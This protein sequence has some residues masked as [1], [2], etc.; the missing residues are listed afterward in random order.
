MRKI[1]IDTDCGV[2]DAVAIMM[3]LSDKRVKVE[4][5]TTVSGNVALEN[6]VDNV[7]RILS[8]FDRKEIPVFRGA[9]RP[10]V[11]KVRRAEGVHGEN[12]LGDVILPAPSIEE[13][14]LIAPEGLY[15]IAC[16]NP[17]I[18]LVTLG[19]LTNIAIAF[20]LFPELASLIGDI[21]IM[22]GA[23]ERGNITRFAEFN[24]FADPESAQFVF[25]TSVPITVIPW[26]PCFAVM[27]TE[28][29]L[30]N[31]GMEGGKAGEFFLKLQRKPIDYIEK[32]YG[33]RAVALPDPAA[34]ACVLD[35]RTALRRVCGNM[36]LELNYTTMRGA[37]VLSEGHRMDI[38]LEIDKN[39]FTELLR[40]IKALD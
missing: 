15:R 35:S 19:P 12:G 30:I 25:N 8:Y 32:Y 38:I 28:E 23:V 36:T 31:L 17:G 2:D 6:V 9:S 39:R 20:N 33:V 16:E 27:Y 13:R 18:T 24:F 7:L 14:D 11:E 4:G 40:Q 21:V 26:D 10:L 3:A 1:I 34:M 5:I 37:S 29:D 22:G